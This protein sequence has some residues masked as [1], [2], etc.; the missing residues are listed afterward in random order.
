MTPWP[1]RLG[2]GLITHSRKNQLITETEDI[3]ISTNIG[4]ATRALGSRMTLLGQSRKEDQ[5]PTAS[6]VNPWNKTR[7]GNWNVRTMFETGKAGQVAR[8]MKRYNLDILGISECRWRGS[9][10]SKLSTGEVIIYGGEEYIH[11]GR[12]A[13]MMSQQ[14]ARCLMEWTSESSR[15]IR[16]RFYLKYRKL[17]LIHAYSPFNDASIESKDDFYEQLE[18]TV[19]KCNYYYCYCFCT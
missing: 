9:G 14:A 17:T 3:R 5:R 6:I 16:A 15:I 11:Q 8:E 2:W 12:V 13:I 1:S 18:G 19:Q 7:I 10:K 4:D